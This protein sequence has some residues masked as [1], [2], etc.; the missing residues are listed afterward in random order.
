MTVFFV[1]RSSYAAL[2]TDLTTF[3]PIPAPRY[4]STLLKVFPYSSSSRR[5]EHLLW[6]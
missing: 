4:I 6:S 3:P 2:I 1:P 5:G